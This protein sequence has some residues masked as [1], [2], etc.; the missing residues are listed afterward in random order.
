MCENVVFIKP[1]ANANI[2]MIAAACDARLPY[3]VP[4]MTPPSISAMT[5]STSCRACRSAEFASQVPIRIPTTK[6]RMA[7][8]VSSAA[9]SLPRPITAPV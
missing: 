4:L 3:C 1:I 6:S 2:A 7:T 5:P 9:K 8:A